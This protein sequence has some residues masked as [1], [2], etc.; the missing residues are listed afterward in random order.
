MG[1]AGGPL[2]LRRGQTLRFAAVR[3][4]DTGTYTCRALSRAGEAHRHFALLVLGDLAP[5]PCTQQWSPWGG[6]WW[7]GGESLASSWLGAERSLGPPPACN[8]G[9]AELVIIP[10]CISMGTSGGWQNWGAPRTPGCVPC[11]HLLCPQF[12]RACPGPGGLTTSPCRRAPRCCWSV[13]AGECP[14]PGCAG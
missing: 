11:S 6:L 12:P 4:E 7:A 9:T 5:V 13:G 2:L 1:E 10:C 3:S 8:F 14:G